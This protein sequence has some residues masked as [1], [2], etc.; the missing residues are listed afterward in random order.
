M[1][2]EDFSVES[3]RKRKAAVDVLANNSVSALKSRRLIQMGKFLEKPFTSCEIIDL[4]SPSFSTHGSTRPVAAQHMVR[5]LDGIDPIC[6]TNENP[7]DFSEAVPE[8]M[9]MR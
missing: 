7:A 4:E 8:N 2:N 6:R 1:E 3:H 9:Y 5:P